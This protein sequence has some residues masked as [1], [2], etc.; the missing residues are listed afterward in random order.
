MIIFRSKTSLNSVPVH[1]HSLVTLD[2]LSSTFKGSILFDILPTNFYPRLAIFTSLLSKYDDLYQPT[3]KGSSQLWMHHVVHTSGRCSELF[4][5][6]DELT[7]SSASTHCPLELAT[8][9]VL[10]WP[11]KVRG[12]CSVCVKAAVLVCMWCLCRFVA[13]TRSECSG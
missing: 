9:P 12:S 7:S 2:H 6:L 4:S 3:V 1:A 11:E 5:V 13:T 8:I 10:L